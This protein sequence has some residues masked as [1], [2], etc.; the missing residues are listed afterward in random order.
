MKHWNSRLKIGALIVAFF[1]VVS[2]VLSLFCP[3][4]D[5]MEW[6]AFGKNLKPSSEHLFGTTGL[7]QDTFWVLIMSLK[8]SL[9][10]G[11][12]TAF[13]ATVIGV[14]LG[15][16]AGLRGGLADRI[17][18]LIMDSLI[19]IPNLPILILFGSMLKGRA[20]W[21]LISLVLIFF[22][23]PW[24]AR[25]TRSMA[26]SLRE[27][28]F[29]STARFSGENSIKII[30]LE[31]FPFVSDWSV[32]NFTNTIL[33]AIGAESTLAFIGMSNNGFPTLGTMIYWAQSRQAILTELWWW[34]GSPV[35]GIT[36]L[37]VALFMTLTGYQNY[38]T[39]KRG[40]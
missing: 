18:T 14:A 10:I 22:S 31:I 28:D 2:Y 3:Y 1:L 9:T 39:M 34:I 38:A 32:A 20:P 16:F 25:Q 19:A 8:N 6:G 15:L 30:G 36:L 29:I 24:P 11:I 40:K 5:V 7:G 4:S 23:W 21:T 27:N 33:S 17:I 12:T 13:F 35:V 26:L 37:F